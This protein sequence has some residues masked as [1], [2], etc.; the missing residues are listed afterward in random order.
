M[1]EYEYGKI[2]RL[3]QSLIKNGIDEKTRMKIMESGESIKT[4]S[5]IGTKEDWFFDA[6]NKM[7]S[8]LDKDTIQKIRE[9]CAC[10]LGGKRKTL[11]KEINQKYALVEER[12]KAVNE[13]NYV[14]GN[15]IKIVETGK[16]E[17]LFWD[18]T[19]QEMPCACWGHKN[20]W[21]LSKIMPESYCLCCGGHIKYF[22]EIILEKNL[23]VKI[24]SST[25][26]S[27][28]KKNCCF[29]LEEIQ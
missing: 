13:T 5:N 22:L 7:E 21:H 18:E 1:K 19:K 20:K 29:I 9:N 28:G 17:V 2:D 10:N 4:S 16:Y 26:T 23:S 25:I 14:F 12:I 3:N 6:M 8:L 27:R 24:L 15:Q 11:C